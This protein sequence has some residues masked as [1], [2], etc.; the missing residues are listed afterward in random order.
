M[1][2]SIRCSCGFEFRSDSE[3]AQCPNCSATISQV[4]LGETIMAYDG[5]KALGMHPGQSRS[6]AFI[7]SQ[8]IPTPQASRGGAMARVDRVFDRDNNVYK[9]EVVDCETGEVIHK[10]EGK[11][12]DHTGHGSDKLN[13]H[14]GSD[15]GQHVGPDDLVIRKP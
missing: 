4:A 8:S 9:E 1:S 2:G 10:A 3:Q 5:N 7:R 6:K 12:S 11:L 13:D 14:L 15:V